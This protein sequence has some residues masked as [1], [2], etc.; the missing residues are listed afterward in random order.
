MTR[1]DWKKLTPEEQRIKVAELCG[2]TVQECKEQPGEY[3]VWNEERNKQLAKE[4]S[5]DDGMLNFPDYLNDLN[6]MHEAVMAVDNFG[7]WLR[8]TSWLMLIVYPPNKHIGEQ[9]RLFRVYNA[10]AAQRAEAFVLA[11]EPQCD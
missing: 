8:Y 7:F 1:E 10:T 5:S 2:L 4:G 11:L 9:D 3:Y 6:A